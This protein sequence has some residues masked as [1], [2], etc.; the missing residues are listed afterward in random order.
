MQDVE[1]TTKSE[2]RS[3]SH[4]AQAGEIWQT[5]IRSWI[6]GCSPGVVSKGERVDTKFISVAPR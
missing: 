6:L 3:A 5:A 2:L 4:S 1:L